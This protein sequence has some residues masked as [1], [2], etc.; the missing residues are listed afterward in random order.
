ME[1]EDRVGVINPGV[2]EREIRRPI[3]IRARGDQ[4]HIAADEEGGASGRLDGDRMGIDKRRGP[5]IEPDPVPLEA[6]LDAGS[7][8]LHH[9]A[10][11]GHEIAHRGPGLQAAL[12]ARQVAIA[13]PGEEEGRLPQGLG[14]QRAG[15]DR[16]PAQDRLPLH[17]GHFLAEVSRQ[18][19]ALLSGRSRSDDHQ[20]EVLGRHGDSLRSRESR[21]GP[22]PPHWEAADSASN[23]P[24]GCVGYHPL[25][26]AH[27]FGDSEQVMLLRGS[28]PRAEFSRRGIVS[29]IIHDR[30]VLNPL[31]DPSPPREHSRAVHSRVDSQ[32]GACHSGSKLE[33]GALK[34]MEGQVEYPPPFGAMVRA[35][36]GWAARASASR[37]RPPRGDR[38]A[39][40]RTPGREDLRPDLRQGRHGDGDPHR[41]RQAEQARR[42][43][44]RE[45]SGQFCES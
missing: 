3:R 5:L 9:D 45:W 39:T 15:I 24:C 35:G 4:D 33:L 23:G 1:G 26:V 12:Q 43:S 6:L 2:V 20:V 21:S 19:G 29:E 17:Q 25:F 27:R 32:A 44:G 34:G 38:R 37:Q 10:L 31:G 11:A 22:P 8:L 7:L 40:L 42:W 14:G 28:Q 13:K 18:R 30:R 16:G 36:P 41:L